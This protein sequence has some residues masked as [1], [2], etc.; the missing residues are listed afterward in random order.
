ME[1][2]L[3]AEGVAVLW[4]RASWN[5]IVFALIMLVVYRNGLGSRDEDVIGL[6]V[7]GYMC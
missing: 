3:R 5:D 7:L 2:C 4:C 1:Q 6:C